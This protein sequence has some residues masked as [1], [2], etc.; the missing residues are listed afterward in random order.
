MASAPGHKEFRAPEPEDDLAA[1]P[2]PKDDPLA[3]APA[4]MDDLA[5]APEP[6]YGL[7]AMDSLLPGDDPTLVSDALPP[8]DNTP[9]LSLDRPTRP[10]RPLSADQAGVAKA[11]VAEAGVAEALRLMPSMLFREAKGD[12]AAE[13]STPLTAD[14]IL[15]ITPTTDPAAATAA[16]TE[17]EAV[18]R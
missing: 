12:A 11:G 10:T 7:A 14:D 4:S 3:V 18:R 17:S 13:V 1:T 2:E 6:T 8:N 9:S 16:P 5:I 15:L